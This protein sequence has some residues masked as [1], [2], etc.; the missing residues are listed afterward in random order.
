MTTGTVAETTM[1]FGLSISQVID[2]VP[3]LDVAT[4][5]AVEVVVEVT[6]V[7]SEGFVVTSTFGDHQATAS[8][9][10]TEAALSSVYAG[11]RGTAST[12]LV[13]PSGQ[14]LAVAVD[15]QLGG[16]ADLI[17]A[18]A[19]AGAVLPA[20]PIGIGAEWK[21]VTEI[22]A[23]GIAI[24]QTSVIRLVDVDGSRLLVE[25]ETQ[26]ELG[27]DGLVLPGFN[28]EDI[29]AS[30]SA[31]GSGDAVWDLARPIPVSATTGIVQTLLATISIGGEEGILNQTTT[32]T[33]EL[34]TSLAFGAPEDTQTFD[35]EERGHFQGTIEYMQDPPVGG[36]HN[37]EW[38]NCGFYRDPIMP[39]NAVHSFEHGAV[40]ITYQPD[41]PADQIAELR[42]RAQTAFTIVSPYPDLDS[43]VVASAWG[44]Q[45][46]LESAFDPRLAEF[47]DWFAAG[48][49]TPEPGA[50]CSGGT[51]D[52]E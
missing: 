39:E 48:P 36:N 15:E 5:V 18:I 21:V 34:P 43:P 47:I 20:E 19:G 10:I 37:P 22:K 32:A 23:Q 31:V 46:R 33:F 40:W 28:A 17:S 16:S 51:G 25:L 29:D 35:I 49:Q 4:D 50:P 3:T 45:L 6:D 27:P 12:Q 2:G 30:L 8:D 14:I 7:T 24:I 52:P 41:L 42:E 9:A 38:Q 11:L 1:R 26:Q 44:V 13:A